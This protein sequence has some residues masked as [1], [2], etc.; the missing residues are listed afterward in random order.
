MVRGRK[1]IGNPFICHIPVLPLDKF[2]ETCVSFVLV[3]GVRDHVVH[4]TVSICVGEIMI[5]VNFELF[6]GV[7]NQPKSFIV[8][9]AD[10]DPY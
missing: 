10:S 5:I 1:C 7:F 3:D 8:E 6:V 4:L 9:A 2:V